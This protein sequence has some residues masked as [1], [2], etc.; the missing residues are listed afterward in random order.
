ME[1]TELRPEWT[2]TLRNMYSTSNSQLSGRLSSY[3]SQLS[4]STERF[5]A[6]ASRTITPTIGRF[7]NALNQF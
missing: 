2:V 5:T 3:R 6:L 4:G 7:Y 1:F